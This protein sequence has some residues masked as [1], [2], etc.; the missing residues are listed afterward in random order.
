MPPVSLSEVEQRREVVGQRLGARGELAD[1]GD[2]RLALGQ[3]RAADVGGGAER[4]QRRDAR[5]REGPELLDEA[6]DRRRLRAEVGQHRRHLVRQ[7]AEALHRRRELAQEGRQLGD[8]LLEGARALGRG[9]AARRWPSMTKSATCGAVAGQ[10]SEDRVAVAGQVGEHAVLAG[11]DREDLVGLLERRVGV[12][13]G[14]AQVAA[15]PG[16]AGAQLVE[17]DRQALAVGQAQRVVDQVEVDGL[18][19]VRRPAAGTDPCRVPSRSCAASAAAGRSP[20][21]AGSACTRRSARRSATAGGS[22][23]R[24]RRGSRRSR[25]DRCAARPRPCGRA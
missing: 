14:L 24:R 12:D 1:V 15:A 11:E 17:D 25:G 6:V 20:A 8:V 4:L 10:R 9:L 3:R 19:G 21:A 23:T 22:C 16:Q 7:P 5:L 2:D 13:D 18:G